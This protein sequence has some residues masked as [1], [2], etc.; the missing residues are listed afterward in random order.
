[1]LTLLFRQRPIGRFFPVRRVVNFSTL[2]PDAEEKNS[3]PPSQPRQLVMTLI[4]RPGTGKSA[5]LNALIREGKVVADDRVG[6]NWNFRSHV[7][8]IVDTVG[9]M[10]KVRGTEDGDT[11]DTLKAIA[12][13]HVTVLVLDAQQAYT[14]GQSLKFPSRQEVRLGNEAIERGK[15]LVVAMNKWDTIPERDQPKLRRGLAECIESAFV[16]LKGVPVVFL[17]ANSG[18]NLN[19]FLDTAFSSYKKWNTTIPASKLNAWLEAFVQHYPPPWKDGQKQYPKFITQAGTRPP[20][21]SLYT[22]TF[23]TFPD[24]YLRQM[25]ELLKE[26]FGL[27]GIPLRFNLRSTLMP[28][29]GK[30]LRPRDAERWRKLGPKQAEA[31]RKG[32]RARSVR[33][34]SEMD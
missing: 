29:P 14:G 13:S 15:S 26:E 19:S 22:N 3:D 31:V 30:P 17:S 7:L 20:T 34:P 16:D 10:G 5:I 6:V 1:M 9:I 28:K 32:G 27:K 21:F 24:N 2:S 4:G 12:K 11:L 23:A 25:K 33:R 8:R 18:L